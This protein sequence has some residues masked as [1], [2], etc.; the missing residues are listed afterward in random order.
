M[1][2][3]ELVKDE[4]T[5]ETVLRL[6]ADVASRKGLTGLAQ[7]N[8]E[9]VLDPTTGQSVV[10]IKNDGMNGAGNRVEIVTDA[11]TGKQTIRM[12]V[13]DDNDE[14]DERKFQLE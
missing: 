11:V 7:T 5:G 2:D 10:R 1:D 6:K 3:F 12:V 8:F 13:D 9:V 4:R 14:T